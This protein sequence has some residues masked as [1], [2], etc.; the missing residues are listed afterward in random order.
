MVS[1]GVRVG[2]VSRSRIWPWAV[3]AAQTILV[4]PASR[5]PKIGGTAVS[6]FPFH[7]YCGSIAQNQTVCKGKISNFCRP[8]SRR[9]AAMLPVWLSFDAQQPDEILKQGGIHGL[10]HDPFPIVIGL[11]GVVERLDLFRVIFPVRF[12][13]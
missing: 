11:R 10:K 6:S 3:A 2:M 4:P 9:S 13:C 12:K 5:A 1:W 7:G 8:V